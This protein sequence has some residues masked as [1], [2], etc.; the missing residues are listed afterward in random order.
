M[1]SP[2]ILDQ[3]FQN[4]SLQKWQSLFELAKSLE[5]EKKRS[6]LFHAKK[7]N[8]REDRAVLH[9]ALR[10]IKQSPIFLDNQNITLEITKVWEQ[11]K[12]LCQALEEVTDIIHIGIGG[13][14]LG[15]RMVCDTLHHNTPSAHPKLKVHFLSNIDSAEA[16]AIFRQVKPHNTRIIVVSKTFATS[17]TLQNT[18]SVIAWLISQGV[19]RSDLNERI[20]AVTA[21]TKAA[22]D[23]G[24]S[25]DHIL[26]F[27]DWVGGRFSVWSAVGLPIALQFGFETYHS[28]LAG[29]NALDEHFLQAP[30]PENQPL[31]LALALFAHQQQSHTTSQAVIP[32]AQAL[33][34]FPSWLQQL[35]MESNGKT[36]GNDDQP[37]S[38]SS[39]VIF[40]VPGTNAQH[41][42]FQMLHQSP[43]IIP[44]DLIA[45]QEPMSN[46]PQALQHHQQLLANCLAQSE[47]FSTG[48]QADD[49]NKASTGNRPNNLIW[50][51]KL[52]AFHLGALMALYE[53]RTFCLGI[54]Y[55]INSFD[56][57]GVEL[58][59]I[60]AKPIQLALEN[61]Q[62]PSLQST[63]HPV[64]QAR[65]HWLNQANANK[66]SLPK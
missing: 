56:Q 27:W 3:Q 39:V 52:D 26:P 31:L 7:M 60:L 30:L 50:L 29:A 10:N 21:N 48:Y 13:S 16:A 25:T 22:I 5:L 53:H 24:I 43:E 8:V 19:Q 47:A 32:Y 57:P 9:T 45:I 11:I 59:K 1:K 20:Y 4:I 55:D 51:K 58:G 34:L 62:E 35:E 64:T 65:L 42:F 61:P 44:I 15:P 18:K 12:V 36:C 46:L 63:L 6:E 37:V 23:F 38:L 14:D 17:E 54:L 40:G 49:P 33:N 28:F 66:N 2:L 41:S